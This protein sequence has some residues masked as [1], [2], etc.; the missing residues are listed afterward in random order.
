M[1]MLELMLIYMSEQYINAKHARD[2]FFTLTGKRALIKD[3]N[4]ILDSLEYK[5]VE[6]DRRI[7]W[8]N[9]NALN[10]RRFIIDRRVMFDGNS[11]M[12]QIREWPAI[13]HQGHEELYFWLLFNTANLLCFTDIRHAFPEYT[14]Q[15]V[16][17][18][19]KAWGFCTLKSDRKIGDKYT[20][21][22]LISLNTF[23]TNINNMGTTERGKEFH[24]I[25][26]D[27][28]VTK[29]VDTTEW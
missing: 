8:H 3:I 7:Y 19:I 16:A 22:T 1:Q 27:R 17:R 28:K 14:T 11:L 5:R 18:I 12:Y 13:V 25:L 21:E 2:L 4:E 20:T 15:K 29:R 9:P 24:Y 6:V 23:L 10:R 26:K